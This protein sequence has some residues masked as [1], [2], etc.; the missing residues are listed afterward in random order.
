[1]SSKVLKTRQEVNKFSKVQ[2][3]QQAQKASKKSS[4]VLK[5][6]QGSGALCR[7]QKLIAPVA[8]L[9]WR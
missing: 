7:V 8:V 5:V 1:M 3:A 4:K 6:P 9:S 2:L